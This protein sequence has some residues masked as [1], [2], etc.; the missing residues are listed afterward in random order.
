M[1]LCPKHPIKV[2][3]DFGKRLAVDTIMLIC[4]PNVSAR[5]LHNACRH[6]ISLLNKKN[7]SYKTDP[8][9]NL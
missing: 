9:Y 4:R 1:K 7:Y 6:S 5:Q 3:K 2:P 8:T